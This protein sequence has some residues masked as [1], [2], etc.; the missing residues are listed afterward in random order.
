MRALKLL[1]K[2]IE[3]LLIATLYILFWAL[4]I[5]LPVMWVWNWIMPYLFQLQHINFW[6]SWGVLFLS[7]V[8]FK[9]NTFTKAKT[10]PAK[11]DNS[12]KQ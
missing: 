12:N 2:A 1:M 3:A 7:G 10:D 11:S 6:Q 9:S 8:L 5:G 4:I